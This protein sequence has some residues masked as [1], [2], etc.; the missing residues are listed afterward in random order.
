MSHKTF[1]LISRIILKLELE[2]SLY[3]QVVRICRKSMFQKKDI[4]K[5]PKRK[6][7]FQGWSAILNHC[8]DIDIERVEENFSTREPHF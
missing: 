5:E 6:Y 3:A 7:L 1:Q 8:F 2:E 4:S